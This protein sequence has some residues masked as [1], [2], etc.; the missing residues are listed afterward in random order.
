MSKLTIKIDSIL[1]GK[2]ALSDFGKEGQFKSA[3]GNNGEYDPA[4]PSILRQ[5]TREGSAQERAAAMLRKSSENEN[6]TSVVVGARPGEFGWSFSSP[7]GAPPPIQHPVQRGPRL[8]KIGASVRKILA[9]SGFQKLAREITG[10]D[11]LD[12]VQ[13]EGTWK[14]SQE[15]S[16]LIRGENLTEESATRLAKLMGFAFAQDATTTC[17]ITDTEH[18][19]TKSACFASLPFGVRLAKTTLQLLRFR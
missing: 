18:I 14:G 6:R 13:I 7:D 2:T 19:D 16:F 11:K 12:V 10:V 8:E 17:C 5:V 9:A 3:T 1:N 4:N 15:P